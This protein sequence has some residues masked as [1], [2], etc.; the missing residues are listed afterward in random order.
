V[1]LPVVSGDVRMFIKQQ[2]IN[3]YYRDKAEEVLAP[4]RRMLEAAGLPYAAHIGIGQ[5]AETIVA[6]QVDKLC[7]LIIM[8]SRGLG[9]V[10][11]LVMGSVATKVV[12]LANVPVTLVK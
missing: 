7:E 12:H 6:H 8:G 10:S 9:A 2:D 3:D 11:G 5:P 1:Q 4:A